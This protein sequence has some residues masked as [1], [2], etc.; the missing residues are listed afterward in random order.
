MSGGGGSSAAPANTSQTVT[1]VQQLPQY[2]QDAASS[3]MALASSLASQPY[4]QYQAPLIAGQNDWQNNAYGMLSNTV[5]SGAYQADLGAAQSVTDQASQMRLDPNNALQQ[6]GNFQLRDP[7]AAFNATSN[8]MDPSRLFGAMG[9]NPG[10]SA[11]NTANAAGVQSFANSNIGGYMSP[12]VGAALAPQIQALQ[13]QFGQQ[14]NALNAQS[15]QAN[16]F[17]DARQ[18]VAQAQN[19]LNENNSLNGLVSQGYNTAFNS[20]QNAFQ[21]DQANRLSAYGTGLS[22]NLQYGAQALQGAQ[23]A[24]AGNQA[25]Q[26]INLNAYNASEN[27]AMNNLQ[28]YNTLFNTSLQGNL[29]QQQQQLAA[30]AQYANLA[31]QQLGL[32]TQAANSV[33]D[34]G[35]Q[36]QQQQQTQ[37]NTAYQQY[38][39]QA[40]WPYQ[41]LALRES[42]ISNNPYTV[43]NYTTLPGS[44]GLTSGLGSFSSIA[45]LLGSLSGGGSSSSTAAKPF[46]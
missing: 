8:Q 27:A 43:A 19:N 25:Q 4:P 12:Y 35:L 39:N 7:G 21:N 14:Q 2:Q 18:G 38:L 1:Q 20:A 10:T 5:N 6:Y 34:V 9:A 45:G 17:G 40:Q 30:G 41:G 33:Y 16:A 36:Q 3:N 11:A 42:A 13:T 37:L 31:G 23:S 46:G 28:G 44:N 22:G 32:G 24:L 15:T 29:A 26:G